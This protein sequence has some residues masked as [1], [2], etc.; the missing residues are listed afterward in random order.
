MLK[1]N[2]IILI[3][4]I[5][6]VDRYFKEIGEEVKDTVELTNVVLTYQEA[7]EPEN[8]RVLEPS[9]RDTVFLWIL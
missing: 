8:Q 9:I 3:N 1:T 4:N 5:E 2:N 7:K 6:D